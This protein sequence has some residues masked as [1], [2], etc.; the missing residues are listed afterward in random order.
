MRVSTTG[1]LP[2]HA[3]LPRRRFWDLS[4]ICLTALGDTTRIRLLLHTDCINN[5]AMAK[6]ATVSVRRLTASFLLAGYGLVAL[7]GYGLHSDA[8]WGDTSHA[9]HS[10][11]S[12]G[13]DHGFAGWH[14]PTGHDHDH[15]QCAVCQFH[16][17]GQLSLSAAGSLTSRRACERIE[18]EP[19]RLLLTPAHRPYRPRGPPLLSA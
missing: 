11:A 3:E 18:R 12:H 14:A 17:Q 8:P 19:R 10:I 2:L 6:T 13:S 1:A 16:S 4:W 9:Q 15:D 5:L 7:V